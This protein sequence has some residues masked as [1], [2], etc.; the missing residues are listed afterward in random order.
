MLQRKGS[1]GSAIARTSTQKKG[2][3]TAGTNKGGKEE[4][5]TEAEEEN[6]GNEPEAN[7]K[8]EGKEGYPPREVCWREEHSLEALNTA[9]AVCS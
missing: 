2:Q 9:F 4:G 5:E 1:K 3:N 8:M 6:V 7:Q